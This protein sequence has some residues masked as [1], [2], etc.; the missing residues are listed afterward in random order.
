MTAIGPRAKSARSWLAGGA[1]GLLVGV[2]VSAL[3]SPQLG[4]W[5]TVGALIVTVLSLHQFGRLGPE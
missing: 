2:A 1:F 4:S 3:A 5:I